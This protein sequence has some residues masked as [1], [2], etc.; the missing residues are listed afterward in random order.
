MYR[1]L[2]CTK[3]Y[4]GRCTSEIQSVLRHDT[5]TSAYRRCTLFADKKHTGLDVV[6]VPSENRIEHNVAEI[7]VVLLFRVIIIIV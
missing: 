1:E 4:A 6:N 2:S 5:D 3:E 7:R